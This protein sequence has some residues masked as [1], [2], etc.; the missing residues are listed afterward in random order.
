ME[1]ALDLSFDR[2]LMMMMRHTPISL[3]TSDI[4]L[5]FRCCVK[6]VVSFACCQNSLW[7]A[8]GSYCSLVKYE[9]GLRR[10]K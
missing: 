3:S 1:E 7:L 4:H 8:Q 9:I 10:Y 2:L 5:F 6:F